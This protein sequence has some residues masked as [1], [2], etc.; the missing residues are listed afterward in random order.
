MP[1]PETI[2]PRTPAIQVGLVTLI[3]VLAGVAAV[4]VVR[5]E[6]PRGAGV[7]Y[8][9][10]I[11]LSAAEHVA[12]SRGLQAFRPT[13]GVVDRLV[14]FPPAYPLL[15][16]TA[17]AFHQSPTQFAAMVDAAALAALVI[18]GAGAFFHVTRSVLATL[19]VAMLLVASPNLLN[20]YS[21]TLSEPVCNVFMFLGLVLL[22]RALRD[23]SRSTLIAAA[24]WLAIAGMTRYVGMALVPVGLVAIVLF[25]GTDQAGGRT[26]AGSVIVDCILFTL[27]STGPLVGWLLYNR[28]HGAATGRSMQWHPITKPQLRS[29]IGTFT[30][31]IFPVER[32]TDHTQPLTGKQMLFVVLSYVLVICVVA[33]LIC[34]A[35]RTR[36][37][38]RWRALKASIEKRPGG[39]LLAA[40]FIFCI[41]Y[42]LFLLV[43]LS[44]VD[45]AT[46]MDDRIFSA[47]YVPAVILVGAAMWKRW[48]GSGRAVRGVILLAVAALIILDAQRGRV[49]AGHWREAGRG[50]AGVNWQS[51]RTIAALRTLPPD[52]VVYTNAPDAV[53]FLTG[54]VTKSVPARIIFWTGKPNRSY[55]EQLAQMVQELSGTAGRVVYFDHG[56]KRFVPSQRQLESDLAKQ[57]QAPASVLRF[58]DGEIF[59]LN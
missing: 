28:T 41:G 29:A 11:Y 34:L 25:R 35:W 50:Y 26:R 43:S 15:L 2:H 12:Q 51:S 48:I 6:T 20:V 27:V 55:R 57:R 17:R 24:A 45:F 30:G 53:Y 7:T 16:S 49:L 47:V 31:W 36:S 38:S 5:Y 3:L 44:F 32:P 54:R 56:D 9:S 39:Y 19:L 1:T 46:P 22:A 52:A 4:F 33:S 58:E 10:V 14:W 37:I 42:L 59:S 21:M 13:E 18:L 23:G 8:D 40:L